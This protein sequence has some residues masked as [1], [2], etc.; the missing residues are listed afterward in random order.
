MFVTTETPVLHADADAFYASVEQRDDP[1]LRGKPVIV[2]GGVVLAASYEARAYGVR[3]AMPGGKARRLC[4]DALIVSP[5][6][7]AYVAASKELFEVFRDTAPSVEGL[8]LEEAFLD[9][10]GLERISGEPVDIARRL[11]ERVRD[12]VGLPLSV[13]VA[14]TKVLAKLASKQAKPDGL[15]LVPPDYEREFLHPLAVE[16]LWGVG[17]ATSARLH[18]AGLQTAGQLAELSRSTLVSILGPAAGRRVHAIVHNHDSGRVRPKR[19][20]RSVGAQS[21]IGRGDHSAA[22]LDRILVGLVDRIGRRMRA[23]GFAGRTVTLRLRY[24]DFSR[25]TRSKTLRR[26]TSAHSTILDAVR[27]LLR[28]SGAREDRRGLTLLGITVSNLASGT[29][30]LT[31]WPGDESAPVDAAVDSVRERFGKEALTR[32]VLLSDRDRDGPARGTI[33]L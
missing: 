26:P 7:D 22:K 16:D 12:E 9:V 17:P 33:E 4:P 25:A 28:E 18:A 24:G 6:F 13:G 10:S 19:G 1:A 30:Q 14:R 29:G 21:A 5:R 20:R 23:K 8:S 11:R 31:L 3:G 2:G 15:L 32:A 27:T